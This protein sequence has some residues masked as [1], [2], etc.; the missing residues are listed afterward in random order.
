MIYTLQNMFNNFSVFQFL[1]VSTFC[2]YMFNAEK[3][4]V[5]YRIEI[6]RKNTVRNDEIIGAIFK[7]DI[8]ENQ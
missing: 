1:L 3:R 5:L 4:F 2:L 7:I 6:A 8:R